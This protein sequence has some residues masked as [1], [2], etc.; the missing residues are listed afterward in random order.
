NNIIEIPSNA[1]YL[2][3]VNENGGTASIEYLTL[4]SVETI[5]PTELSKILLKE[6]EALKNTFK[7][8]L[9]SRKGDYGRKIAKGGPVDWLLGKPI[10]QITTDEIKE[11][12]SNEIKDQFYNITPEEI[13]V[14][15]NPSSQSYKITLFIS[16]NINKY[17]LQIPFILE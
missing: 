11:K 2:V 9:F 3:I 17:I 6:V 15:P 10:H 12:L 4:Y 16:D 14:E 8:W 13:L 7:M 1:N 5:Q